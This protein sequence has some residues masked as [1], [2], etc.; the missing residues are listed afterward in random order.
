MSK[1]NGNRPHRPKRHVRRLLEHLNVVGRL[2]GD[3]RPP[4]EERLVAL[5]GE[6]QLRAA[7]AQMSAPVKVSSPRA[8]TAKAM[9]ILARMSAWQWSLF[10]VALACGAAVSIVG[11]IDL[12][13]HA[14]GILAALGA[15][16]IATTVFVQGRH[17]RF[18]ETWI[19][20]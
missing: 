2:V 19:G 1:L 7:R 17:H 18:K 16:A 14:R 10:V 13:W 12:V 9:R 11:V 20:S 15:I 4:A 6:E 5:L 3:E 8:S